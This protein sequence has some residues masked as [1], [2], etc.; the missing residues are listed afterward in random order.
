MRAF[1]AIEIPEEVKQELVKVQAQL[2]KTG[3]DA[4]WTRREGMH[5]T[6][7]FLGEVM[8]QRIPDIMSVLQRALEGAGPLRLEVSGVGTF[9]NPKNAR[10]VWTG[11][12]GD[13]EKLMQY[14]SAI[15][16]AMVH[17]GM[18]REERKFT[19]HLTLCR[20]KQIRFRD[21]WIKTLEELK[22]ISL[23]GFD[24]NSVSL[25]QSELKTSGAVYTEMGRV[26]L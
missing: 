13:I 8:E 10:V 25:M 7:K 2:K 24:V 21:R 3:L 23:S 22:D 14:Q 4:S 9:P 5:L 16:Q 17:L 18:E 6:L 26:K 20:V 12:S 15:E 1:I 19:P 11:L